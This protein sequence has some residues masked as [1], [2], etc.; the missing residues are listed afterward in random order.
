MRA[1][2]EQQGKTFYVV[3]AETRYCFGTAT[4]RTTALEVAF[5]VNEVMME[6]E[7]TGNRLQVTGRNSDVNNYGRNG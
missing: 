4:Y 5:A 1:V 2:I 3:D 6:L 7:G